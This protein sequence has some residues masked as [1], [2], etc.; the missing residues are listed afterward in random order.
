ML[1]EFLLDI[2]VGDGKELEGGW[3]KKQENHVL[4]VVLPSY[5]MV[6]K[7]RAKKAAMM[8]GSVCS[9][10]KKFQVIVIETQY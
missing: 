9:N 10:F 7:F 1:Q 2:T 8:V 5:A 3:G 6:Q 4:K